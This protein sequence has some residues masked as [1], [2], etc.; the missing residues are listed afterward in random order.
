MKYFDDTLSYLQQALEDERHVLDKS[1][2]LNFTKA[3]DVY[4]FR[5]LLDMAEV[6]F[7]N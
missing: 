6:S 3:R 7:N 5:N 4:S 2:T 1:L